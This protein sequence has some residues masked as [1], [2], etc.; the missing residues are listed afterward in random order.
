MPIKDFFYYNKA[1]RRA[2]FALLFIAVVALVAVFLLDNEQTT[3]EASYAPSPQNHGYKGRQA[4]ETTYYNV[5]QRRIERFVFD[6]NTA[7]STAFL[8]LGL[9]P[10]Q[11]RNIYK[12]RAKG[13]I[14]RT[15]SD[16]ARL[17]GLTQKEYLSL[18]P[19]IQIGADYQ[20]AAHL[21]EA[22]RT[23]T[24]G[25]SLAT[26]H[27]YKLKPGQTIDLNTGDT[28][29]FQHIPGI[30]PYYARQIVNYR[31]RLGGYVKVEQLTEI[32]DFPESA[33]KYFSLGNV[34]PSKLNVNKLSL[35]QLRRHPYI[36]F[37]QARDIVEYRRL[38]GKLKQ[39][40]DLRLL[41][42]F[43][44]EAIERLRPYVEF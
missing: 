7:D 30:G 15:P 5:P 37:Y 19:Y 29:Q 17:Y 43:P 3:T 38:K 40:N 6:P 11:V 12:Y 36:N 1:D 34:V 23:K 31:M 14:Y 13:G 41:E 18:K 22:I 28:T 32:N 2:I 27:P 8:R 42:T 4:K 35:Y 20:P 39:L 44:P 26:T 9:Q 25:D 21:A 33:L 16:F 24:H 10:W